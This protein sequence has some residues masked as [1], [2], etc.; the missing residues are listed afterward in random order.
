MQ[1]QS[2]PNLNRPVTWTPVP[3][4]AITTADGRNTHAL[5]PRADGA[6]PARFYRLAEKA[7][8][9]PQAEFNQV[10][11]ELDGVTL[12]FTDWGQLALRL[13]L[14][15]A[16]RY[17][18]LA[19]NG[20]WVIQNV[21]ILS[22]L[23]GGVAD[24]VC[25]NFPL[26]S[27]G[28]PVFTANT[29]FTVTSNVVAVLPPPTNVTSFGIATHILASGEREVRLAYRPAQPL[30][31]GPV[32]RTAQAK[33][34]FPNRE[35]RKNECAPAAIVNSLQYLDAVFSLNLPEADI[36]LGAIKGAMGW[37]P[38][39]GAPVG[40]DPR[41]PEWVQG[42]DQHMRDRN[43]PIVT[44][45]TTNAVLALAAVRA[46]Y[47]VEVRMTGHAACVVGVTELGGGR[48]TLTLSHDVNQSDGLGGGDGG[49]VLETVTL[50]TAT[51][52]L[53]GT[54]WGAEFG[55]FIIERPE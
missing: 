9:E 16:V 3:A 4:N 51:G 29:G 20:N 41:N 24:Q 28:V 23:S 42:K 25:L 7:P 50:D 55:T 27:N 34:S 5:H 44:E 38:D 40:D 6:P 10:S 39:I 19:V 35:Q 45:V 26:G 33:P 52:T 12:P 21:P 13:P 31:G 36:S 18:N 32:L 43:L 47:D 1:L 46:M 8:T 53:T 37:T 2:T 54:G 17:V 15:N 49:T 11:M 22:G 14:S 48:Y 30:V